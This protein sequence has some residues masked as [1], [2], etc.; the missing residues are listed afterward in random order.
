MR[1]VK[2]DSDQRKG[3]QRMVRAVVSLIAMLASSAMPRACGASDPPAGAVVWE[4]SKA[5]EAFHAR[6]I[7]M[8]FRWCSAGE[9]TVSEN[10]ADPSY[11]EASNDR[12]EVDVTLSHGYWIGA[13][14]V[15]R[16]QWE[17]VMETTPWTADPDA[18]SGPNRPATRISWHDAR[19]F[20]E[21]LTL[22]EQRQGRLSGE[23]EYRLPTEAEWEYA[24]MGGAMDPRTFPEQEKVGEYAWMDEDE[25]TDEPL[26]AHEVG[27]K[28]PNAWGLHDMV[29]NAWEWCHDRYAERPTG[30]LDPVGPEVGAV[31]V[32]RGGL[33]SYGEDWDRSA[34][35]SGR[36][37][38]RHDRT[39]GFR[40]V[41]GRPLKV[42]KKS[43]RSVK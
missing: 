32:I 38:D 15:S 9:F 23:I 5:G 20:C 28:K 41:L 27:G 16:R 31:R 8:V 34:S 4:G 3:G 22:S 39:H 40:V 13:F 29:G 42:T 11:D 18:K 19:E 21:K 26:Y 37:P 2:R 6:G 14:E 7:D 30:G 36:L 24:C 10:P 35:R 1:A 12:H 25:E 17:L 43:S 33:Q